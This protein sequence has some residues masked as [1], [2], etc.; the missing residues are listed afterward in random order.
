MLHTGEANLSAPLTTTSGL[1]AVEEITEGVLTDSR[2]TSAHQLSPNASPS[3]NDLGLLPSRDRKD[4]EVTKDYRNLLHRLLSASNGIM[5]R[6]F[7]PWSVPAS[8]ARVQT[9]YSGKTRKNPRPRPRNK[10]RKKTRPSIAITLVVEPTT[11][12]SLARPLPRSLEA[13]RTGANPAPI[14]PVTAFS[15]AKSFLSFQ[16]PPVFSRA[17]SK[18]LQK[19]ARRSSNDVGVV[20]GI[21]TADSP[22]VDTFG[23]R[24]RKS[25]ARVSWDTQLAMDSERRGSIGE[26]G[27]G[28]FPA[29]IGTAGHRG[30]MG[31][32]GEGTSARGRPSQTSAS[33]ELGLGL[34]QDMRLTVCG[35]WRRHGG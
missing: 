12:F 2:A 8:V 31:G 1:S 9:D 34:G 35:F 27:V 7:T 17:R 26:N 18:V 11:S 19:S 22:R 13:L 5:P 29:P 4:P 3:D 6:L 21:S 15:S 30:R 14:S 20:N 25:G 24:T 32:T 16:L 28:N 10:L 23:I 33:W